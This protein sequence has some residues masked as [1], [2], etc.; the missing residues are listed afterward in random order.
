[1]VAPKVQ[2]VIRARLAQLSPPARELAGVAAA[3]GRSFAYDVLALASDQDD[4]TVVRSLD[5][6]WQRRIIREQGVNA[7]DFSHDRLRDVAYSDLSLA[8]RR[9]LHRRLAKALE[10]I[11]AQ[12]T[13]PV[14]AQLAH[15]HEHAGQIEPAIHY[16]RAAADQAYQVYAYRE[17]IALLNH[18]LDLLQSLP[19]STNTMGLELEL[20]MALCTAWAAVT[21]YLGEEVAA[22]Y[23][24]G[25]ELCRQ[26]G[27]MPHLFT[28]LWGLHEVASYRGEYRESLE[29]AQECLKIAET[30]N[31]PGL[32]LEAHHA[33]W[34]AY[35][36]LGEYEQAFSHIER[37]L[38]HYNRASHEALSIQYGVHDA[39]DC[40]L[41]L[42]AMG[43]WN[44]GYIDQ[45]CGKLDAAVLS[46]ELTQ[47]ANIAD[48]YAYSG[49]VLHLL[50]APQ[51]AQAFAESALKI[52]A[53][54]GY[55][56]PEALSG[57]ALGWSLAAQGDVVE[58]IALAEYAMATSENFG[59][60]LHRSQLA[61]MLAETYILAGRYGEAIR[62]AEAGITEFGRFRDLLC[63]PDLWILKGDALH[64]LGTAD[65]E[66]EACYQAAL[67]L[68][69]ELPRRFPSCA[70]R[71]AW[72]ACV[73]VR[74]GTP[75]VTTYCA[76]S[77][78]GSAKGSM[79]PICRS[80]ASS[81]GSCLLRSDPEPPAHL[82]PSTFHPHNL[83]DI[84]IIELSI[85]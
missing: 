53:E 30:L 66:V 70:Q 16:L 42:F 43:L 60:R 21:D 68:A 84:P 74:V 17:S 49:L 51:R 61:A 13:A 10:T 1:M 9:L 23:R 80:Q 82:L 8:R 78:A 46:R 77:T 20:Q 72:R 52:S 39:G 56:H 5:E 22:A 4:D 85:R 55:P 18:G 6:L 79:L 59:Q 47:P 71:S 24:R 37:G 33:A 19:T 35:Y 81:S 62:V 28:V 2:A 11:H 36:Y 58:G 12:D 54:K 29:L 26:I 34:G 44:L 83:C 57:M 50:R 25:L 48:S 38:T 65:D 32:W 64:A 45:A 41:H 3:I 31:D 27:H 15:H 63:A 14:S 7:Y 67:T 75:R 69:R 73:S 40:A 76:T